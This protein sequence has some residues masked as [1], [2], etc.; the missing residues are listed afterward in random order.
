MIDRLAKFITAKSRDFPMIGIYFASYH[1]MRGHERGQKNPDQT[2]V[3]FVPMR[4]LPSGY[5]EPDICDYVEYWR[6]HGLAANFAENH[7]AKFTE[8]HGELC[9]DDCPTGIYPQQ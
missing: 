2:T 8:N 3:G 6:T 5:Y 1:D 4:K 7:P 9:P